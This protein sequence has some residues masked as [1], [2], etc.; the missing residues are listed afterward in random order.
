MS[1]KTEPQPPDDSFPELTEEESA[2]RLF[3]EEFGDI[4]SATIEAIKTQGEV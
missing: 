4:A 2:L 3:K 1:K